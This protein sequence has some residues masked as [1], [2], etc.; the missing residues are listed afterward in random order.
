LV[1]HILC[2][3]SIVK[4]KIDG[5]SQKYAINNPTGK[6]Q[7]TTVDYG[8]EFAVYLSG[9]V[10]ISINFQSYAINLSSNYWN[11][12]IFFLTNRKSSNIWYTIYKIPKRNQGSKAIRCSDWLKRMK[13]TKINR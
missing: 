3:F 10:R 4:Q 2:F 1:Y 13:V 7:I 6:N 8:F 12:L 5:V 11:T 9:I